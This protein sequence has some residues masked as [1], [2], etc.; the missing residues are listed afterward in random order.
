MKQF[1]PELTRSVGCMGVCGLEMENPPTQYFILKTF[2][3][4]LIFDTNFLHI[5]Y[6]FSLFLDD[7]R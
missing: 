3:Y 6:S 2:Q 4:L 7:S 1:E 5:F